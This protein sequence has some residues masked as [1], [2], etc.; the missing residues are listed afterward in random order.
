MNVI[1]ILINMN[2]VV[3]VYLVHGLVFGCQVKITV[4]GDPQCFPWYTDEKKRGEERSDERG[5]NQKRQEKVIGKDS[6]L[7][8]WINI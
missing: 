3:G 7:L 8:R 6:I 2:M 4:S 1:N 5:T